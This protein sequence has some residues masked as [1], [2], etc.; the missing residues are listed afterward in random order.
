[1]ENPINTVSKGQKKQKSKGSVKAAQ[2]CQA[3]PQVVCATVPPSQPA[4]PNKA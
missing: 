1:M 2:N 3:N 4:Q